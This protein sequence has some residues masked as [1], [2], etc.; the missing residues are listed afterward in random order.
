MIRCL[1]SGQVPRQV[2]GT[3]FWLA[4]AVARGLADESRIA[5]R[6]AAEAIADRAE[7]FAGPPA[8]ERGKKRRRP[9]RLLDLPALQKRCGGWGW[10]AD[11][12]RGTSHGA[13][14]LA[15]WGCLRR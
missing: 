14:G 8:V 5:D 3:V 6:A 10:T 15:A 1:Y 9:P 4:E 13:V 12:S 11:R 7:G 2:G